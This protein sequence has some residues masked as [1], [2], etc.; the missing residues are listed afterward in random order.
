MDRTLSP[1]VAGGFGQRPLMLLITVPAGRARER[2][3]RVVE[4][5][6]ARW[7]VEET[8]RVRPAADSS[9]G[10]ELQLFPLGP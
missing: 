10:S 7:R 6:L 8:I 1:V 3:W 4:S 5:Y 2:V 9:P